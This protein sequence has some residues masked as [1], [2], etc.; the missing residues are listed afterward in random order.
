MRP[1][2]GRDS[3][4]ACDEAARLPEAGGE[5]PGTVRDATA[6]WQRR[7]GDPPGGAGEPS[8]HSGTVRAEGARAAAADGFS[9]WVCEGGVF[10]SVGPVVSR[11]V[12]PTA[13]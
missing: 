2:I 3:A 8:V 5:P 11:A 7:D 9:G 10:Y 4:A 13:V 6:G 1:T 12:R